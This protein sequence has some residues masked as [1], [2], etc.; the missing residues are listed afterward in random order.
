MKTERNIFTS[1]SLV[2][3]ELEI[4]A[5]QVFKICSGNTRGRTQKCKTSQKHIGRERQLQIFFCNKS[6]GMRSF[7]ISKSHFKEPQTHSQNPLRFHRHQIHPTHFCVTIS[8][9]LLMR[10]TPFLHWEMQGAVPAA[11]WASWML[12]TPALPRFPAN[13]RSLILPTSLLSS[14]SLPRSHI[15]PTSPSLPRTIILLR[16][17]L[18][19]LVLPMSPSLP[20]TIILP[21]S[22]ALPQMVLFPKEEPTVM[23]K[24]EVQLTQKGE[25]SA[26]LCQLLLKILLAC[27]SHCACTLPMKLSCKRTKKSCSQRT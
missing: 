2:G 9:L 17:P 3:K 15:L 4:K 22:P 6:F 25:F 26:S 10:L 1:L 23:L 12:T 18:R 21:R 14:P 11:A 20:R 16:S 8:V 27:Y 5:N 24:C 19:S 7:W 13:P